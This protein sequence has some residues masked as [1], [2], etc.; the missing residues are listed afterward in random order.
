MALRVRAART[1][2]TRRASQGLAGCATALEAACRGARGVSVVAGGPGRLSA[3][4][5]VGLLIVFLATAFALFAYQ[6]HLS[7]QAAV[8]RAAPGF[9]LPDLHGRTWRLAGFRGRVVVLNFW[10]S[11]CEVC[12][13]E[14]PALEAFARRYAGPGGPVV[15]L[16]VDWREPQTAMAAYVRAH[17]LTYPNLRDADGSVAQA[18]GLTGV[19]ET[20]F[21]DASG[22]ARVH[23][24]GA[25]SFE[26]LQSEYRRAAGAPIDAAGVGPV[27]R[28]GR[29]YAVAWGGGALWLATDGGLWRSADGGR[30]WQRAGAPQLTRGPVRFVVAQGARL[31]AGGAGG[32]LWVSADGGR[33]WRQPRRGLP[34]GDVAAVALDPL[35]A[36]AAWAWVDGGGL[37]RTTDGGATWS[38]AARA[39]ALPAMPVALAATAN[40]GL[41]A[42]TGRG[43]YRSA[44]GG[45][46]WGTVPLTQNLAPAAELSAPSAVLA[47]AVPLEASAIA[48]QGGA[49]YLAGPRGIWRYAAGRGAVLAASPARAF[50]G[51]AAG[52][53]GTLWAVAPNGDLYRGTPGGASW[54]WRP[55]P[56]P[57]RDEPLMTS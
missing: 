8:G 21:I 7:R 23:A 52:R 14:A 3:G 22:V 20:W 54:S 25:L 6:D 2:G 56:P 18:Y 50:V 9:A 55:Q 10:A 19:P 11:W 51:I 49:L 28:G 47:L 29:A 48:V 1:P 41:W 27:P 34:A 46:T 43:V 45:R 12:A 53:H 36:A 38:R 31:Y 13:D 40:G 37:Y 5:R 4:A 39:A 44:D 33:T 26:Q 16:G 32:G 15:L 42:A 24:L 35:S 57:R 30:T 17:G